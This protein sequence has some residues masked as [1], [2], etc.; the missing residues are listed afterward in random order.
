MKRSVFILFPALLLFSLCLPHEANA[1][2]KYGAC[3]EF[4]DHRT[5]DLGLIDA[6]TVSSGS[7]TFRNTGSEPLAIIR[8]MA[9]CNCTV[10]VYPHDPVEPGDSATITV[11]YDS[12][13]A[14][15][16]PFL[17]IIKVRSDSDKPLVNLF[18]KG[19][20]RRPRK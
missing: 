12:R 19:T 11:K 14:R 5:I 18:V 4:P 9:D 3:I 2:T 1:E 7:I 15:H 10:P 6:D 17:K 16:G 20:I 13:G 8:V